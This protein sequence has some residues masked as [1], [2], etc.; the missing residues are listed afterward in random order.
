MMSDSE[1]GQDVPARKEEEQVRQTEEDVQTQLKTVEG[2]YLQGIVDGSVGAPLR[3]VKGAFSTVRRRIYKRGYAFGKD[4]NEIVRTDVQIRVRKTLE[5]Q[6]AVLKLQATEAAEKLH[7]VNM[8]E[9]E[10]EE[11]LGDLRAKFIAS[12]KAA[13]KIATE[14]KTV[15]SYPAPAAPAG[16]TPL[17]V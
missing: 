9:H 7:T 6:L 14:G 12:T 15:T 5:K 3:E 4:V 11:Q 1:T 16:L 10:L 17:R 13:A 2:A 8:K